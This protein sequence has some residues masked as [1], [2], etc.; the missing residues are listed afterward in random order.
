MGGDDVH[1]LPAAYNGKGQFT[2]CG[3]NFGASH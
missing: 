3:F 2:N 1:G